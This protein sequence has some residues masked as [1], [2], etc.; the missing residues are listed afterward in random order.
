[1]LI[2][3]IAGDG[4]DCSLH[5]TSH[6]LGSVLHVLVVGF[7]DLDL[8]VLVGSSVLGE[9][10][11]VSVDI[12]F[13]R[14]FRAGVVDVIGFPSIQVLEWIRGARFSVGQG[15]GSLQRTN[16][17]LSRLGVTSPC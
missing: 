14:I 11:V 8:V 4:I 10:F 5:T 9:V 7:I 2:P 17:V 1:M 13:F 3:S 6:I 16:G 12:I 15:I